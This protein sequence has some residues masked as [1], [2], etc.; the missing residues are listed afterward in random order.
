MGKVLTMVTIRARSAAMGMCLLLLLGG[1]SREQQDWRSAEGA[2]TIESYGRFIQSHPDSELVSQARTR[3]T[4]LGEDRDWQH[5]GSADTVEAYREFLQQHPTGKWS[6]E[7]RIRVENF[8]LS[9]QSGTD[10]ATRAMNGSS[11]ATTARSG[12]L[13][14]PAPPPAAAPEGALPRTA[15]PG[16]GPGPGS[17]TS[18]P[19]YAGASVYGIQLG[20]FSSPEN[21][22]NQWNAL[23]FRFGTDLQDLQ[24]KVVPADT[25]QGR[26]Y[27][28]QAQ[29]GAQT[30]ARG[31]CDSLRK[32]GQ[33]CVAVLPH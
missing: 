31:V 15:L 24:E 10:A 12:E 3:V 17:G 6:Q 18:S 14:G 8:S 16:T 20:A 21:A 11:A 22:H 26:I 13:P 33:A 23:L 30:R 5:A 29:V 27:R 2:D 9:E 19:S 28:L 32:Q 1:C 7:A 4:Q 25:P